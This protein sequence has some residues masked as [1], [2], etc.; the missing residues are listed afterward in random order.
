MLEWAKL[1]KLAYSNIP[2]AIKIDIKGVQ[3]YIIERDDDCV[4]VFRGTDEKKDWLQDSKARF[5]NTSYGKMHK[6]FKQ[7]WDLVIGEIRDNLPNKPLY[8]TGHSYG[9]ALAFISGLYLPHVEVITFGCP[10]VLHKAYN[11]YVKIN[12]TRVRNNNDIVTM[13]PPDALDYVHVGK[14]VY[15]DY[16]GNISNSV[17]FFDRI[18][19]HIKAWKK[20]EKFNPFYD[21]E[22]DEYIEKLQ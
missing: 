18:K 20:G 9:G 5:V 17:S 22:I 11:S 21:H 1:S 12:H 2:D 19:S 6:G 8:I 7:S 16:N 10:K 3:A 13:M 4:L 15:L 14:L